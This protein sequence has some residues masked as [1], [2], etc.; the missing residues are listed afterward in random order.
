[1]TAADQDRSL[2]GKDSDSRLLTGLAISGGILLAGYL[3]ITLMGDEY[4]Y[5]VPNTERPIV[6]V[7]SIYFGMSLVSLAALWF[8]TRIESRKRCLVGMVLGFA[9]LFRLSQLG[10]PPFQEV[11]LYRYMWDGKVAANGISPYTFSPAEARFSN[12]STDDGKRLDQ[13]ARSTPSIQTIVSRVHFG[14]YTTLYPPVSQFVFAV[15]MKLVPDD[16]SVGM[17]LLVMKSVLTAFDF[18]IL[19]V[20]VRLL[21]C[22]GK[23]AGWSIVYGWSPL[24][25]KEFANSGHLDSI[26]ELFMMLA[27][28]AIVVVIRNRRASP[29]SGTLSRSNGLVAS[30][31]A[32]LALGFGAKLFPILLA[33]LF[34]AVIKSVQ[35]WRSALLFLAAFIPVSAAVM[36]PM[37]SS[38]AA[39]PD[40]DSSGQPMGSPS[41]EVSKEGLTSFLSAWRMNDLAFSLV[42]DNLRVT[43]Q[44]DGAVDEPWCRFT[45]RGWRHR[46]NERLGAWL[47]PG[48]QAFRLAR[49]ITLATWMLIAGLV[50]ARF[51]ISTRNGPE[52][53]NGAPTRFLES[54]FLMIAAFFCLLP[55]QNPWYWTWALPLACFAGNR[56]WLLVAPM[57]FMYYLRFWFETLDGTFFFRIGGFEY[58]GAG[59][60]DYVVVWP[61]HLVPLFAVLVISRVKRSADR[62]RRHGRV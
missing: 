18:G 14:D 31:G 56:G 60:F 44:P 32:L 13:L 49:V 59:L 2:P 24:V 34:L 40:E 6:L 53:D 54:G 45:T 58:S 9:L 23:H 8:A 25:V 35:G 3:S 38:P 51:L 43:H 10:S 61:E 33:P 27:L 36:M 7:T 16:A 29:G 26:A 1:M 15:A 62:C 22:L 12:L 46:L 39:R 41:V 4:D 19:L 50:I 21:T 48:D 5:N 52:S 20:V 30:A 57:L 42:Y 28:W 17:H 11:D 55:T 37:L 47:P